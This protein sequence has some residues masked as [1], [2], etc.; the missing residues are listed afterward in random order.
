MYRHVH[1]A[2]RA[3]EALASREFPGELPQRAL[4]QAGRQ[5]MLAMSS[6]LPFV[7]SNGHFIDRMKG[8]FFGSLRDFWTLH[9]ELG[10]GAI[11]EERLR[12]LELE[13]CLFPDLDPTYFSHLTAG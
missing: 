6:D 7:I 3:Y 8:Q 12:R 9:Q 5:L 1:E 10:R 2:A 4:R 11:N 13:T